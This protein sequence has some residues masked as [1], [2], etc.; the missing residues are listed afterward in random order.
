MALPTTERLMWHC[1]ESTLLSRN[2]RQ[3]ADSLLPKSAVFCGT[4]AERRT[5]D[6]RKGS[7][8]IVY[9]GAAAHVAHSSARAASCREAS[10]LRVSATSAPAA[11]GAPAS[12]ASAARLNASRAVCSER[13]AANGER[14]AVC[15]VLFA[16]IVRPPEKEISVFSHYQKLNPHC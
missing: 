13:R 10:G 5:Q 4:W 3:D 15:E 7:I 6:G 8:A 16:S 11:T 12:C 1:G 14:R 2:R 9:P